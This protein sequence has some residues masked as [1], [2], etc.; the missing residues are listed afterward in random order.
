MK[1]SVIDNVIRSQV[2]EDYLY[3][4]ENKDLESI[5]NIFSEDCSLSDWNVGRIAGKQDVLNVY[6]DIF[7]SVREIGCDIT[8]IHE[9]IGGTLACE[10]ELTIDGEMLLVVDIFEFDNDDN[11]K[12]LRAYRG[13]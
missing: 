8:H 5:S 4:F 7:K 12:A 6:S 10:M 1:D 2:V 13:N 3:F 11:I 9:D